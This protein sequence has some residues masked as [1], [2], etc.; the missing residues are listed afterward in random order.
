M[1]KIPT[2]ADKI[3]DF[4]LTYAREHGDYLT[5]LKLQKLLYYA[6]AW[7]LALFDKELFADDLQAWVHGPVV[8]RVY[9]RFKSYSWNPI[10]AEVEKPKLDAETRGFLE[11]VFDRYGSFSAV[12]LE[13]MTHE[14]A[15]WQTA[16]GSLPLHQNSSAVM[17]RKEIKAFFKRKLANG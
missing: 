8:S 10:L 1:E 9:G 14:E 12:D 4:F 5:N 6:Q 7:H 3:A 17:D 11:Q 16:R 15:P 2:K 13:R